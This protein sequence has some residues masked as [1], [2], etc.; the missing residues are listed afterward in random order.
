[1]KSCRKNILANAMKGMGFNLF[2]AITALM[3]S[4][5]RATP[6][7]NVQPGGE[8]RLTQ[9]GISNGWTESFKIDLTARLSEVQPNAAAG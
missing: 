1:M 3:V 5:C 2:P 8:Q 4:G 7:A 6:N 9:D